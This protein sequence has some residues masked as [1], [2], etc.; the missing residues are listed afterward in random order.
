MSKILSITPVLDSVT[1][2]SAL[3][4]KSALQSTLAIIPSLSLYLYLNLHFMC[5]C[6]LR[7]RMPLYPSSITAQS[8]FSES[9]NLSCHKNSNHINFMWTIQ[10]T[11]NVSKYRTKGMVP[12]VYGKQGTFT[13]PNGAGVQMKQPTNAA[14]TVTTGVQLVTKS[15]HDLAILRSIVSL[16]CSF[17]FL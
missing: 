7:Y 10:Y 3:D 16:L 5:V 9:Y 1:L 4:W 15:L 2:I 11:L 14:F 6:D 17:I 8:L 13:D 12:A